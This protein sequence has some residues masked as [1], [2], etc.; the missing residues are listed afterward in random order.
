MYYR[1]KTKNKFLKRTIPTN[2][3]FK[4]KLSNSNL[5]DFCSSDIETV[6]PLLWDCQVI[7][8]FWLQ[9]K[10]FLEHVNINTLFDYK[11]I[12]FGTD[13]TPVSETLINCIILNAKHYIFKSK[14]MKHVPNITL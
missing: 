4:C 5:C 2:T 10:T 1:Y 13:G 14:Y 7:E 11:S 9:L 8:D 12:C 6:K 3:L